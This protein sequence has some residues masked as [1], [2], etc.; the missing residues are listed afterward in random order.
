VEETINSIQ[1]NDASFYQNLMDRLSYMALMYEKDEET[2]K[3][4]ELL[5]ET[6][7]IYRSIGGEPEKIDYLWDIKALSLIY[8]N[9]WKK[10]KKS[11]KIITKE[12][13]DS[14]VEW[15]HNSM[16]IE[17]IQKK[18]EKE[19]KPDKSIK[20]SMHD[21]LS[22][23]FYSLRNS[24]MDRL[25][26]PLYREIYHRLEVLRESWRNRNINAEEFLKELKKI[27]TTLDQYKK[28]EKKPY[29]KR[30]SEFADVYI[31]ENIHQ[32]IDVSDIERKLKEIFERKRF[33]ESD[34]K[35]LN[36]II[37]KLL[38]KVKISPKERVEIEKELMKMIINEV[39]RNL[40]TAS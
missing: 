32:E 7:K 30:I 6:L 10:V 18:F 3:L 16:I 25:S 29:W 27:E 2:N 28:I 13:W 20:I 24:I 22:D 23:Y 17:K 5:K 12:L 26:N 38:L 8:Y 36:L 15:I 19:I 34:K 35:E 9:F 31:R 21:R 39:R 11:K 4:V 1:N 14:V 37:A 40:W 33:L